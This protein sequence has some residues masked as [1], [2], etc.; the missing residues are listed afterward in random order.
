MRKTRVKNIL[1]PHRPLRWAE[2]GGAIDGI[3]PIINALGLSP[4][5]P[6]LITPAI[7]LVI[8]LPNS[9]CS[10][11]DILAAKDST[12]GR[13]HIR[14]KTHTR[15]FDPIAM[16]IKPLCAI[17]ILCKEMRR[18]ERHISLQAQLACNDVKRR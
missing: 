11:E 4:F 7:H 5:T 17:H 1:A 14:M 18:D 10:F 9:E 8:S 2:K 3:P 16:L 13:Y 15:G 12:S 6:Q